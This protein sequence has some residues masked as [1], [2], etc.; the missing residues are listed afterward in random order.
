MEYLKIGK[1]V[2]THGLKGEIKIISDVSE[3][4]K[5][6][7]PGNTIYIG[8]DKKPFVIKS[9]RHHQK[10]DMI[11]LDS[12]DSIESVL[13]YKGESIF[14]NKDDIEDDLCENL[15]DYDVYNNDI[16]IGK[17]IEILKGV[18]YDLIVVSNDRIII[19]FIDNFVILIDKDNKVIKTKYMI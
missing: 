9:Y 15:L 10:Y 14:F 3:A 16:Y 13:P 5:L 19:P 8:N 17:V 7:N 11:I 6:F 4:E 18:K 12:L 1:Y 2:S